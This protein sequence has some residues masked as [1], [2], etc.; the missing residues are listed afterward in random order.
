[1][2]PLALSG[3]DLLVEGRTGSGKTLAYLLPLLQRLLQLQQQQVQ[4]GENAE[5]PPLCA[6]VLVPTKELCIQVG[7]HYTPVATSLDSQVIGRKYN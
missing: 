4:R 2:I 6:L 7:K 3:R 5:L 1:M